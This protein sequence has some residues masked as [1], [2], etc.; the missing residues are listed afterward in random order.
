MKDW[1]NHKIEEERKN[2]DFSGG[3][4]Y[5][6]PSCGGSSIHEFVSASDF[7][8]KCPNCSSSLDFLSEDKAEELFPMKAFRKPH[9]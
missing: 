4:Y 9:L 8:F 6:C 2:F 1:V 5:F 7:G 3:E